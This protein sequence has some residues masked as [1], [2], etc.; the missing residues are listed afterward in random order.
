MKAY[1]GF[2]KDWSCRGFKYEM[3]QTYTHSGKLRLCNSGF[4]AC[5][6][7]LDTWN[8]YDPTTSKYAEVELGGVSDQKESDT[9]RVAQSITVK[10]A[11]DIA[12]LVKAQIEWVTKNADGKN[13]ASGDDSTAAS[14]GHSSKAASSGDYSKA[15]SSGHSRRRC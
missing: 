5:E 13:S 4:H 9:K 6:A 2:D 14:S 7:P 3:G 15:A 12:G 1:K 8:Y 11:L 10:A